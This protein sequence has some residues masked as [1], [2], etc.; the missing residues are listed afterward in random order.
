MS[1]HAACESDE[2]EPLLSLG[3]SG[4]GGPP[5]PRT[6]PTG[7]QEGQIPYLQ[8]K[9]SRSRLPSTNDR[10]RTFVKIGLNAE[11]HVSNKVCQFREVLRGRHKVAR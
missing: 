3:T 4:P 7:N 10:G 9:R 5:Q 11:Q 1:Q 6:P 2:L 8:W